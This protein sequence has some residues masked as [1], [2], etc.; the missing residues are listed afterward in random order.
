MKLCRSQQP[1]NKKLNYLLLTHT[2]AGVDALRLRLKSK[3]IKPERYHLDTIAAWALR[4]ASSF[5]KPSGLPPI[6][7]PRGNQ[8]PAVYQA[9][10]QLLASGSVDV[11]IRASY[12]MVLVDEYQ[13]CTISQHKTA[14]ALS[15]TVPVIVFGDPLQGIFDFG[16]EP[17]V[18]WTNNVLPTFPQIDEL[19]TPWRWTKKGNDALAEWLN[20]SGA[21]AHRTSAIG[22]P[23]MLTAAI[24]A[25]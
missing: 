22:R 7:T 12:S 9:A 19:K 2:L 15:R 6:I 4:Y 11:V 14:K 17:I 1:V 16:A 3:G 21:A 18:N 13:D 10:H 25:N 5:P 24:V 23:I 20:K 8:W